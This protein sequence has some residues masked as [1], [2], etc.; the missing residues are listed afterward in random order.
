MRFD[1]WYIALAL[2]M[3]LVAVGFGEYMAARDHS[4]ALVHA[5]LAVV[6]WVS[7]ALFGL[8]HR[9]YPELST[10]RLALPQFL[11]TVFSAIFFI[12]GLWI[13]MVAGN[14]FGAFVGSYAL[15]L[16]SALFVWMFFAKVVFA[17]E[18][19]RP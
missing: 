16:G 19:V 14:A 15:M 18:G 4:L 9:A 8:V 10:S 1:I 5:H 3:L 13:V 6:G 12:A 11:L 2:I 17:N 7:F